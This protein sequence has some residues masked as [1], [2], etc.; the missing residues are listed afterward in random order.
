VSAKK[1][2]EREDLYVAMCVFDDLNVV[3]LYDEAFALHAL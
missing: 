3:A 1:R 2:R